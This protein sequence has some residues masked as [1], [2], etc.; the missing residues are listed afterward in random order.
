MDYFVFNYGNYDVW[1]YG[2]WWKGLYIMEI[3]IVFP[4]EVSYSLS[5]SICRSLNS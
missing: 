5:L 1:L 3:L 4:V 2:W